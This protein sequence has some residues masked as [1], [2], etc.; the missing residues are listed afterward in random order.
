MELMSPFRWAPS[1]LVNI[2]QVHDWPYRTL[3]YHLTIVIFQVYIEL[4]FTFENGANENVIVSVMLINSIT[5]IP[6]SAQNVIRSIAGTNNSMLSEIYSLVKNL[7]AVAGTLYGISSLSTFNQMDLGHFYTSQQTINGCKV[8][9]LL[10]RFIYQL[11]NT[12]D[13]PSTFSGS[14]Y[15]NSSTSV[16][17][18]TG[19]LLCYGSN[20]N[21]GTVT[22]TRYSVSNTHAR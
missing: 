6:S 1:A 5:A 3:P 21:L 16:Q 20:S 13:V 10:N 4:S 17:F 7:Q 8:N 14:P 12:T 2:Q 11:P 15:T 18:Q 22:L 19:N 9:Y